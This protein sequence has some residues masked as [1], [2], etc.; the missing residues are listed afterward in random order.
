MLRNGEEAYPAMIAAIDG[1]TRYVYLCSYIFEGDEVGKQFVDALDRAA[2]RGVDVR[3]LVDGIGLRYGKSVSRLLRRNRKIRFERFLPIGRLWRVLRI[4]LR[5]HR[6]VLVVDGNVGFTGGM[7]IS[8]RHMASNPDNKRATADL[9]FRFQGPAVHALEEVFSEDWSFRVGKDRWPEAAPSAI[10]GEA[11]CRGIKDGP[12]E[13][14]E[15]LQW[16]LIGALSAAHSCVRILTPY[17]IPSRELLAAL[18]SAVLRGAT[19]QIVLPERSNLP[20]VDWATHAMLAEVIEYDI[21]VYHQPAPFD[22]SKLLIVDDF[23]VNLGSANLDPRSLQLNFEF[24]VEVYDP[25]LAS[26]LR[27]HVLA[28]VE[29]SRR[30]TI[31][32]LEERGPLVRFRDAVA[33][34]FSPYL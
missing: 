5:N 33:K 10:V 13:D 28:I 29:R 4:N 21:E 19:V 26:K 17:F 2:E 16:I 31:G 27:D 34:I 30:V 32:T 7:N 1:A 23:Y 9:H 25:E 3:V 24:N 20:F 11:L 6:K 18:R 12:N 22:H 8:S 15:V 14:Y